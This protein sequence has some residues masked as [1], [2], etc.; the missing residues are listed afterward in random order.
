MVVALMALAAP[1]ALIVLSRG[2]G[3]QVVVAYLSFSR[4]GAAV[5]AVAALAGVALGSK[6]TIVLFGH[7]WCTE[8]PRNLT[9]TVVL[10]SAL[11]LVGLTG[12]W[13]LPS[14]PGI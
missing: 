13:L 11:L 8:Q 4:W 7:L 3:V 9:L 14:G 10:W 1:V 2:K 12:Y 5:M 6:R